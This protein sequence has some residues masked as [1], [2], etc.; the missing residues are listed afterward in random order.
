MWVKS[1]W[2]V[3]ILIKIHSYFS[4]DFLEAIIEKVSSTPPG[5]LQFFKDSDY[6]TLSTKG[7][8]QRLALPEVYTCPSIWTFIVNV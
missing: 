4:W 8:E 3:E 5:G 7:C 1:A 2:S 6:I